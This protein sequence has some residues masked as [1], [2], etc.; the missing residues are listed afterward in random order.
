MAQPNFTVR[1]ATLDDLPSIVAIY[2]S[3]VASRLVTADTEEVTVDS[4]LRWFSEHNAERRPLWV[5]HQDQR[6][7]GWASLQSFYGR[8]AYNATAEISI[9]LDENE[10]GKGLGKAILGYCLERVADY[11]IENVL[12]FIFAHNVPS[13]NLFQS[14]GFEEWGYLPDVAELDGIKRSLKILGKRI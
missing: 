3:T 13:L 5:F 14:F 9:Y 1:E 12:G 6:L 8:P 7:V 2:N 11:G 4:R 10:R